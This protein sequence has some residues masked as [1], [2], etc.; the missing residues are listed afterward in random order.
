MGR[1]IFKT[2]KSWGAGDDVKT[3]DADWVDSTGTLKQTGRKDLA[4]ILD[5]LGVNSGLAGK[6]PKRG[7]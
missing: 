1:P 4:D 3:R 6:L 2:P 7:K 5:V